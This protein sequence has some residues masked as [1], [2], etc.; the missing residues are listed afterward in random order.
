[1]GVEEIVEA[2]LGQREGELSPSQVRGHNRGR[3]VQ[4]E[5]GR[6]TSLSELSEARAEGIDHGEQGVGQEYAENKSEWGLPVAE[7][8]LELL[9]FGPF[10]VAQLPLADAWG[11]VVDPALAALLG[12]PAGHLEG[13]VG[14]AL[15][16]V[17]LNEALELGVV[18][19]AP[20]K[21]TRHRPGNESEEN[22][23][24]I[25]RRI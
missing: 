23:R 21:A 22:F 24:R 9:H 15:V 7:L 13:D 12:L 25:K 3:T 19:R 10:V 20:A 14:P 11:Q 16:A 8:D 4:E 6:G 2:E 5:G 18:R 17:L 1:M